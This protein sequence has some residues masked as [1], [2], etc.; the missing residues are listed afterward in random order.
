MIGILPLGSL[1]ARRVRQVSSN[2]SKVPDVERF[3]EQTEK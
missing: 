3:I 2:L 1:M